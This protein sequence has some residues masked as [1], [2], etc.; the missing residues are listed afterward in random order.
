LPVTPSNILW[1]YWDISLRHYAL[2]F[3]GYTTEH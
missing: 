2:L 1:D 3:K